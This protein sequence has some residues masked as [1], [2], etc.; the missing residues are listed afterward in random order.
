MCLGGHSTF[1]NVT[2]TDC[3]LFV[4]EGAHATLHEPTLTLGT[5]WINIFVHGTGSQVMVHGGSISGGC[6]G[7]SVQAGASFEASNLTIEC[8]IA[9][10]AEVS[11]EGSS[12]K[13]SSCR[14]QD[15]KRGVTYFGVCM[16]ILAAVPHSAAP[17][18]QAP[19]LVKL[20]KWRHARLPR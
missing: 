18:A 13:L 11:G 4:L 1:K 16:C 19:I 6:H 8:M 17:P 10:G 12:L 2:F 7:V 14:I 3:Q 5:T 15:F 9:T 20:S